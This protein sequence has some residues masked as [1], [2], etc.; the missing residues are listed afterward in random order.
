VVSVA[1]EDYV[2]G[3]A[4]AET[5]PLNESPATVD[6]IYE[7][8]A[9]LARS[10]ATSHLGRHRAEGFDLCDGVHCQLYD[11]ARLR[12]SRFAGAARAAVE[13]TAGM[14]L[15]YSK[16]PA[17]VFFHADCG[18]YTAAADAVWGGPPVPYLAPAR[19]D[20]PLA[21]HRTWTK[22]VPIDEVRSALNADGRSRVGATLEGL[23]V[24]QRDGS[25]RAIEVALGGQH[26]PVLR[27]E[28][29][30][31]ILNQRLGDT[32]IQST[33][34]TVHRSGQTYVFQGTGFGHGVG[35][36]QL[37][38]A[39]RARHGDSLDSILAAYFH[40]ASLVRVAAGP[41]PAK[42]SP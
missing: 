35:L 11:P 26:A 8:Q 38:A 28:D 1:L 39:A 19:D 6:R 5:S 18:G 2:L 23:N 4:L 32:A 14:I 13:R 9:V 20:P 34:F 17:E 30:R 33:R 10:Y 29:F 40:G 7:V 3:S 31:A 37:G 27:G 21:T 41:T 22:V 15:A 25:G 24:R 12:T 36:C 42:L 16:R